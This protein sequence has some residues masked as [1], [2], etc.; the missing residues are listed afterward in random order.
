VDFH[1]DA[2]VFVVCSIYSSDLTIQDFHPDVSGFGIGV[3]CSSVV[4]S[5]VV[6]SSV[7]CSS[8]VCSSVV[9]SI[10]SGYYYIAAAIVSGL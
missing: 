5:S 8:V 2:G 4:C 3:V 9:C 6:C 7:V 1:A 10:H